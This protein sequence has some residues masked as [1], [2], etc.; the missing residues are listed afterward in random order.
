MERRTGLFQY[1][2]LVFNQQW[3]Q[4]LPRARKGVPAKIP[5]CLAGILAPR[6]AFTIELQ[7]TFDGRAPPSPM[8]QSDTWH[9][10]AGACAP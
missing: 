8:Q 10:K 6:Q 3:P 4:G 2:E 1:F 5:V 7:L 9:S